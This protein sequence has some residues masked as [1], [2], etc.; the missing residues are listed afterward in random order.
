MWAEAPLST[1]TWLA[2]TLAL[3]AVTCS[4]RTH[5]ENVHTLWSILVSSWLSRC[6]SAAFSL[7]VPFLSAPMTFPLFWLFLPSTV[8]LGTQGAVIVACSARMA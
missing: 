6:L 4:L 2:P 8:V 1:M 7:P 5:V 3:N